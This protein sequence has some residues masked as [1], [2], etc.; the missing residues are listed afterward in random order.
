MK[1]SSGPLSRI[2]NEFI[3]G[4]TNITQAQSTSL[5]NPGTTRNIK[6]YWP[7]LNA[8]GSSTSNGPLRAG[9]SATSS[10]DRENSGAA[11]YG[12]MN[13]GGNAGKWL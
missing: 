12:V 6:C 11:Y 4:T 1:N 7:R 2:G 10:T 3:W 8:Y 5:N 13:L 9:F